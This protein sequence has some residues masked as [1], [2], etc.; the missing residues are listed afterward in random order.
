MES[1]FQTVRLW[2]QKHPQ[3]QAVLLAGS[4]A[5]G[6]F[7]EDSDVDLCILT[8][9]PET[10]WKDS[11]FPSLFGQPVKSQVEFYGACTSLR[12]WYGDGKEV[13]FGFMEPSWIQTPLDPGT[14]Q[15]LQDGY[16]ILWDPQGCF[17]K[18]GIP[19]PLPARRKTAE[20]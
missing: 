9:N 2:A 5:R 6:T 20:G 7:R 17:S 15:V 8:V 1:F 11:R 12:V 13:E 18:P 3:I 14:R 16:Q 19:A 4:Y 10:F